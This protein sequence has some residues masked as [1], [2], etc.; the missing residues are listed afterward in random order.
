[1][2]GLQAAASKRKLEED[3]TSPHAS[4]QPAKHGRL[5][6]AAHEATAGITPQDWRVKPVAVIHREFTEP[7]KP[8]HE[9]V[10][11]WRH[12]SS[13]LATSL[14]DD[15]ESDE[16]E[17][18]DDEEEERGGRYLPAG[19][20]Y[21]C[22]RYHGD[23][24]A[25]EAK[26]VCVYYGTNAEQGGYSGVTPPPPPQYSRQQSHYPPHRNGQYWG[27]G[28]YCN[29]EATPQQTI[30]CEENGKSYLDL[31]S[32][33]AYGADVKCCDG[34]RASWCSRGPGATCYRQRRLAVLNI[35]M[36]K[37]GRY[38]QF[39]D[40]SLHRSVLICNT[41]R[42][43]ER[44]MEHEGFF[45]NNA[46]GTVQAPPPPAPAV[47]PDQGYHG[48][49]FAE[50]SSY[51]ANG[52]RGNS[53]QDSVPLPSY[54]QNLRELSSSGR[55]TPFPQTM[56]DGDSGVGDEE[57]TRGINWGSVLSLSS[58]SD[59]DPMNN[60]EL[61]PASPTGSLTLGLDATSLDVDVGH[62]FE[63]F[64]PGW[65]LTPLSADDIIKSVPTSELSSRQSE[66]ELDSIMHVLVGT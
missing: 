24:Y 56:Y 64:I 12:N 2:M 18:D 21:Q 52:Y 8:R 38:R 58:Q 13:L 22:V 32:S 50:V 6:D 27:N 7:A 28:D 49:Q 60:N 9:V 41:L 39:P 42:H 25:Q 11:D 61:Y 62:E 34:R 59:L 48:G 54:E 29:Q 43:I 57:S 30:R 5:E 1:M 51:P 65:K 4:P 40:P 44:E 66:G 15:E 31:G 20:G 63:S 47:E 53:V 26:P 33:R 16:D 17:E 3:I 37:L 23:H 10:D 14:Q 36:C 46:T 55:A 19:R 45:F 35:S